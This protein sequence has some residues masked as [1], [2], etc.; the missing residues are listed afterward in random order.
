MYF[1]V[2][3]DGNVGVG[4]ASPSYRLTAKSDANTNPAIKV[5]QTGNTDGW[6]FIPNNTNGNLEFS[7]IGGGTA[8]THLTITNAGNVGVGNG[9]TAPS[10]EFHV[11]G[12]GTVATFEGTGGTSFISIKDS[13]DG[14]QA[15]IGVDAGV[16]KFQTSGSSYSDKLIINTSGQVGIGNP[17][18]NRQLSLKHASQAEIGF[19]TG[20]VS[21]GALIY[22]NDS[23]NQLLLR[24][25]ES[26]EHIAFQTGGTTER[27]RI[28][29]SGDVGI[30][31]DDPNSKLHIGSGTNTAVTVGSQAT[32][33]FQIGGTNNYR[34]GM[35]TDSETGYIENKNGDDG[36][37]FRVKTAG[38]A[39]R[40]D[41][42]TGNVGIGSTDPDTA[43]HIQG[44]A[45]QRLKVESTGSFAD[46][47]FKSASST[48]Q[49]ILFNDSTSGNNSGVIKYL[50]TDNTMRFRTNDVDDQLVIYSS[51][52]LQIKQQ[53]VGGFGAVTTS[54][55]TNW[56][57]A[58]NARSGMGFTLL[59]GSHSNG[60]GG[61]TY[62]HPVN[63]EYISKDGTGNMTQLAIP[64]N[65]TQQY[66]RYRYSGTWS[67]WSAV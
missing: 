48:T 57:D 52:S 62:Y 4:T 61:N 27:M 5:E 23:E 53:V 2:R 25:Q 15:F 16:L 50:H 34:L 10:T 54:G 30:G 38:E 59:L 18:P 6:G 40:I 64:Y 51:G 13:D 14:T 44:S 17:S 1:K 31:N 63:Y 26:G 41:G 20:S 3:G 65:G 67:S 43:L 45:H 33:A 21:N 32:P 47:Q 9:F 24:A 36:I 66:I 35:Y 37:A 7:R 29:S 58:T 46:L 19:K 22:Y 49:W 42:G 39:M 55:T 12:G 56:N 8:G 28:D 11:K 60:P